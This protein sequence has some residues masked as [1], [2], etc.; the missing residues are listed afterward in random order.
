MYINHEINRM[1]L[2]VQVNLKWLHITG[3]TNFT[4]IFVELLYREEFLLAGTISADRLIKGR[5]YTGLPS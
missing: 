2:K 5:D 4:N 1:Y 3:I